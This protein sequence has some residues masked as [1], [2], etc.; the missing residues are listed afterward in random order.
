[1]L[2][3]PIRVVERDGIH[4]ILV[5]LK[6][7]QLLA[8]ASFPYFTGAVIAASDKPKKAETPKK[9]QRKDKKE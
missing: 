7:E 9:G 8:A 6:R 3:L 5:A 1:M 4:H 2:C